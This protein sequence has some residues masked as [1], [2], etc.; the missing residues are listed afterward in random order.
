MIPPLIAD[1]G[2]L[3]TVRRTANYVYG[4]W[5]VTVPEGAELTAIQDDRMDGYLYRPP[6]SGRGRFDVAFVRQDATIDLHEVTKQGVTSGDS[7]VEL[8]MEAGQQRSEGRALIERDISGR[9]LG[10]LVPGV[11]FSTGDLVPVKVWGKILSLPVTALDWA[12][13][14]S[15][16]ASVA[17]RVGGQ[18]V[19]DSER[20][21]S[22]NDEVAMQIDSER[23]RAA[24]EEK[25][26]AEQ[27]ATDR[28]QTQQIKQTQTQ[29]GTWSR[30]T[31]TNT[32]L[33]IDLTKEMRLA[34]GYVR[35]NSAHLRSVERY[36]GDVIDRLTYVVQEL[37]TIAL[38]TDKKNS[39]TSQ[40][41]EYKNGLSIIDQTM[42]IYLDEITGIYDRMTA[43]SD[44]SRIPTPPTT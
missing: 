3:R 8:Q 12:T 43:I 38:G 26:L 34:V 16:V 24:A 39:V 37:N 17:V 35:T 31:T 25:R 18:L 30:A 7:D 14:A 4:S 13:N 15:G 40:L 23:R 42:T 33:T 44:P 2:E 10:R 28:Q 19:R 6:S 27:A 32:N 21:R 9:G 22:L 1:A 11:D 5:R 41:N 20:L 29:I 36:L